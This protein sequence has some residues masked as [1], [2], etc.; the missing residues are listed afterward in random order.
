LGRLYEIGQIRPTPTDQRYERPRANPIQIQS[1]Q[2]LSSRIFS[3]WGV[4]AF[5][6]FA[7]A[8]TH[9]TAQPIPSTHIDNS[10]G[11][12]RIVVSDIEPASDRQEHGHIAVTA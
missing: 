6:A 10:P 4:N 9:A 3:P 11:K 7:F 2:R 12:P 1:H 5:A 8:S